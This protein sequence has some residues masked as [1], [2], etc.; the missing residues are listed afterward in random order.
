LRSR[1]PDVVGSLPSRIS[2]TSAGGSTRYRL[3]IGP[4]SSRDQATRVCNSLFSAGE[5]DCLVRS[6]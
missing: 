3:G 2:Q 1:Y 5:R 6:Q 4:L